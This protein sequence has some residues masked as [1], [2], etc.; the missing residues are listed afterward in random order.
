MFDT[1]LLHSVL[2]EY[3]DQLLEGGYIIYPFGVN[4]ISIKNILK[5]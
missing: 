4:G 5:E 2:K 3:I 1:N